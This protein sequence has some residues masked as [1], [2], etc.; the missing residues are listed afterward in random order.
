MNPYA[1]LTLSIV[2]D[3][4]IV[5]ATG[6]L[7]GGEQANPEILFWGAVLAASKGVV[8]FLAKPPRRPRQR[9]SYVPTGGSSVSEES[10]TP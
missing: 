8:T 10:K 2:A 7:A 4:L 9:K 3:M 6:R 5:I 1:K